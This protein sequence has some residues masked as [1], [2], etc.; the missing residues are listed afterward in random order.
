MPAVPRWAVITTFALSLLGFAISLYL[1]IVHFQPQALA[2]SDSGAVDCARVLT[3][4]QSYFLGIPVAILGLAQYSVM[5]VLCSPWLWRRSER[6][7]ALARFVL[8]GVGV[9][10]IIWLISAELLII[11]KICLWCT[12]V[13]IVTLTLFIVLTRVSPRQLGWVSSPE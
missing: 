6:L 8:G 9:G 2:C 3:S 1:T 7:I 10:F 4:D 11:D 5:A 13:H 12:G